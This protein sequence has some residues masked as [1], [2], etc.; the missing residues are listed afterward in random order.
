MNPKKF[1]ITVDLDLPP[2][3]SGLEPYYAFSQFLPDSGCTEFV[4]SVRRIWKILKWAQQCEVMVLDSVSGRFQP[5]LLACVF[6]RFLPNRPVVLLAGD[7]WN[8]GGRLKY[9]FQKMIVR[10]ADPSIRRYIVHSLGEERMFAALWGISPQKVRVCIY[11]YTFTDEEINTGEITTKGY[12]F[13]GGNP[14]RDY[15]LLMEIASQ[16]P[17][18]QFIVAARRLGNRKNIPA[19][20]KVVQAS[21]AEFIRLMQ[22]SDMVITPLIPNRTKS[23]GQQTYL[24][25]MRMGKISIVNGNDVLGVTDYIQTYVNGIIADGTAKEIKEIIEWVYHP[26]TQEAVNKIKQCAQETVKEFS[27]DRHLRTM[28]AIIEEAAAEADI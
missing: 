24:N 22:E 1:I 27:Y 19:N 13:A 12:I 4:N 21:H 16:L 11:H 6:M 9:F 14:A 2:L 7:M 3:R 17:H 5:D 18:R 23:S 25:A 20:V 8:K 26:T 15:D 28:M 10:L